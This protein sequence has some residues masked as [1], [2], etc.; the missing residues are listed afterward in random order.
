MIFL[1]LTENGR[2][3]NDY[4]FEQQVVAIG[5]AA[6]CDVVL[7]GVAAATRVTIEAATLKLL[8]APAAARL[9]GADASEAVL[10]NGDLIEI[11]RHQLRFFHSKPNAAV[12]F[13]D[14]RTWKV[15]PEGGEPAIDIPASDGSKTLK[16]K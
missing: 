9:N 8:A 15:T 10:E 1:R 13:G 4:R 2:E 14:T 12:T 16:L 6:D 7:P 3:L 5:G 11:G